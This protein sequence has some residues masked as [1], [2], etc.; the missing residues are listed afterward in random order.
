MSLPQSVPVSF[1]VTSVLCLV[2]GLAP[3]AILRL[4]AS[5]C[6]RFLDFQ[7]DVR[8]DSWDL[9]LAPRAIPTLLSRFLDTSLL[10][11]GS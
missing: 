3:E 4:T 9:G 11:A 1:R 8:A 6:S 7:G 5:S 2:L 10:W